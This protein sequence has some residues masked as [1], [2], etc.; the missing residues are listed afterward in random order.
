MFSDKRDLLVFHENELQ[1]ILIRLKLW[2]AFS[3]GQLRCHFC[4][5][6]ITN[7]NFGAIF[8][9]KDKQLGVSCGRPDCL[10]KIGSEII[11]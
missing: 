11:G 3:L 2:E 7:E 5:E 9:K 4:N 10:E 8:L 1:K 6:L